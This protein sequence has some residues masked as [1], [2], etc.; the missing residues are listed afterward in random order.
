M[1]L[2]IC[3]LVKWSDWFYHG[4]GYIFG[5]LLWFPIAIIGF[6]I[7]FIAGFTLMSMMS[8]SVML[9]VPQIGILRAIGMESATIGYIFIFQAILYHFRLKNKQFQILH[10][11]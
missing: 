5:R 3:T 11:I 7:V 1:L 10:M 9:K 4:F 2:G 8:L 6:L